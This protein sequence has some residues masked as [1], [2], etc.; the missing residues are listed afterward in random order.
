M[1]RNQQQRS[2]LIPFLFD[3]E[4]F[5]VLLN[6]TWQQYNTFKL[7][8]LRYNYGLDN[9]LVNYME[10]KNQTKKKLQKKLKIKQTICSKQVSNKNV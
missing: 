1:T 4:L 5:F 6:N 9:L 3:H 8:L 10:E 2:V 7:S